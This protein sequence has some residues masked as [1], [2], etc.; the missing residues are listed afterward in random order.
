MLCN[1]VL[2]LECEWGMS[3]RQSN[4]GTSVLIAVIIL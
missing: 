3:E 1:C 2:R 4:T